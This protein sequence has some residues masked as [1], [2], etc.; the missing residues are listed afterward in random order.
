MKIRG[1]KVA[2]FGE[3]EAYVM[4]PTRSACLL[5]LNE[6]GFGSIGFRSLTKEQVR[7]HIEEWIQ[8]EYRF[9]EDLETRQEPCIKQVLNAIRNVTDTY[10]FHVV[11]GVA[12]FRRDP[13]YFSLKENGRYLVFLLHEYVHCEGNWTDDL[14]YFTP[15]CE[16]DVEG[17]REFLKERLYRGDNDGPK[18]R[19]QLKEDRRRR[20]AVV[21]AA[22]TR[23][24]SHFDETFF[25][26]KFMS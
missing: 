22:L 11:K 12:S 19:Q 2:S 7:Q 14:G 17:F 3:F 26:N 25:M 9:L 8:G 4:L 5:R 13:F 18:E 10:E 23:W 20:I 24:L 15:S 1:E 16:D 21:E 6:I